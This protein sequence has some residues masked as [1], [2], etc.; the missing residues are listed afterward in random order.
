LHKSKEVMDKDS[1]GRLGRMMPKE[2]PPGDAPG[3]GEWPGPVPGASA[4]GQEG[5]KEV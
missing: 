5:T 2:T 1:I 4:L 3:I